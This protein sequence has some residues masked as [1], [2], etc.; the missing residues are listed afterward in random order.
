M[1]GRRLRPALKRRPRPLWPGRASG[2]RWHRR[3]GQRRR[4]HRCLASAPATSAAPA[5]RSGA[6]SAAPGTPSTRIGRS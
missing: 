6:A 3:Q 2:P 4:R 5:S 1:R